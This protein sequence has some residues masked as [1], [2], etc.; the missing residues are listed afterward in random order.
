[1]PNTTNDLS[2]TLNELRPMLLKFASLQ[3]R[4][5][6]WAE[7]VVSDTILAVLEKPDSF[8][9]KSSLKTW[10]IGILKHKIIDI[11]R[12][13]QH[14]VYIETQ[15]DQ[16]T[17]DLLDSLFDASGHWAVPTQTWQCPESNYQ[18]QEFFNILEL[19]VNKLPENQGRVFMMR[20]WLEL[21]TEEICKELDL[22]TSNCWVILY[23]AR[24]RLRECLELNWL[25]KQI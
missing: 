25:G 9:G 19:C 15:E 2:H 4:H 23:R 22:T 11:L 5:S 20:E 7:D 6:G 17:D 13:H 12:K 3:L 1:M 24:M 18:E 21:E 14:E 16:H 10:V 8:S